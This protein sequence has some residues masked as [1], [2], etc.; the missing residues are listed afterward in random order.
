MVCE[1]EGEIIGDLPVICHPNGFRYMVCINSNALGYA[2]FKLG[3][4]QPVASACLVS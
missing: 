3:T 1:F 4:C 2:H